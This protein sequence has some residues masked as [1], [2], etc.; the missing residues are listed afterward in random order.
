MKKKLHEKNLFSQWDFHKSLFSYLNLS[1]NDIIN[2]ENEIIR[3]I[4][5]IDARVGKRRLIKMDV[6]NEHDL[7][8]KLFYL[9]CEAEGIL[10][11]IDLPEDLDLASGIETNRLT[12][13][14]RNDA[15]NK[16]AVKKLSVSKST[17]KLSNFLNKIIEGSITERDLD[18]EFSKIIYKAIKEE[19]DSSRLVETLRFLD[20]KSKLLKDIN[21]VRG[22]I[23]LVKKSEQWIRP[24]SRWN[25][26][27][28]NPNKQF[29]SLT[30]HLLAGYPVPK[31]MDKAWLTGNEVH[32]RWFVHVGSGKNIRFA[33]N[34]PIPLT[35]KSAHNFLLAP[36][37]YSIEAAIRWGQIHSLGGDKRLADALLETRIINDFREN[38]FWTSVIRF[39]IRNPMLD[40]IHIN[41][42][43]DYIWNKKYERRVV[44]LERGIAE[45]IDP[46][47]PNFSMKGRTVD[48]ILRQVENWHRELGREIKSGNLQ[49]KKSDFNDFQFI[50]GSKKAKNMKV[51]RIRE[52]LS[53]KEL[54][55][56]GKQQ[57]HCVATYAASC[58][59]GKCSIWTMDVQTEEG[60][61]K[62]LTIEV[63]H[64]ENRIKQIRGKK[65]RFPTTKEMEIVKRWS[66]KENLEVASYISGR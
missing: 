17:R 28:H 56:E 35:K 47:Q 49:W 27:S 5:M 41:P 40:T 50:E 11:L 29:Y 54:V 20:G 32:Q 22:I 36:D 37:H 3:A 43:I 57:K 65:N 25:I 24:L 42:I 1:I 8:R 64:S 59:S 39:F 58:N 16:E 30:R 10:N 61:E 38:K 9:R 55:V 18:T 66:L 62:L 21:Y 48:S 33:E 14:L 4:G 15:K 23:E 53:S 45:E 44:F 13:T 46:E 34:L 26:P 52:L 6:S 19:T 31:F 63:N 60:I 2:S 7:V 12:K 51:W